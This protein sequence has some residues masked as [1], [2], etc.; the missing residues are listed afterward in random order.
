VLGSLFYGSLLG[1]FVLAFFFRSVR[2][3]G[4]F[5]GMLLGEAFVFAAFLF[6]GISFLWYNVIGCAVVV[7]TA[8]AIN[9]VSRPVAEN[10]LVSGR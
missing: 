3:T 9:Q 5:W 7:V 6:T 10:R 2:G 8:L 1:V 4:A